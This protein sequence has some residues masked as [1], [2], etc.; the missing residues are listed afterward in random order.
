MRHKRQQAGEVLVHAKPPV[1]DDVVYVHAAAE[2]WRDK[3]L[4]R[5]EF[6]RSYYPLEIAGQFWKAISWTT[7]S[8]LCAVVEL[9]AVGELP[10][11]GFLRQEDIPL[12]KFLAT[13]TGANFRKRYFKTMPAAE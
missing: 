11:R 1:K 7:A 5:D 12:D 4:T 8:S 2:G 3:H 6:V 10:A 9:V 13:P